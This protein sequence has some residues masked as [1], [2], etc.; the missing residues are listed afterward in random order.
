MK[1]YLVWGFLGAGKTTLINYLLSTGFF[2]QKKVVILE[3]ESGSE[4]VDGTML[5]S[6][7]YTVVDIKGGCVCCTLRLTLVE[8][9]Q[10]IEQEYHPDMVWMEAS[11]L[12]SLEDLKSIPGL[13]LDGVI[14]VLDV[15]QYRFLMKLNPVFYRRQFYF[16][17]IVFLTKTD[18]ID[19]ELVEDIVKDLWSFQPSLYIVR[20]YEELRH[21]DWQTFEKIWKEQ[22]MLFLP[23]IRNQRIP[24][25]ETH[26]FYLKT[27]VDWDFW[28]NDFV[29]LNNLFG[30]DIIRAKGILTDSQGVSRKYD[31]ADG[32]MESKEFPN[33]HTDGKNFLSIWWNSSVKHSPDS[34]LS[35]F[36]NAQELSCS[37]TE[38]ELKDESLCEFLNFDLSM[39]TPDLTDILYRLKRE[40]LAVCNPRL[41]V[42]FVTGNKIDKSHLKVGGISF[43]PSYIITKTL[44]N[45]DFYILMVSTV[46]K[47]L[48]SWIEAKKESGD[49]VEAFIADGIGSALAEEIVAYG[50]KKIEKLLQQWGLNASN[51]YSPGYCDWNVSEQKM[52]FSLL[53]SAFC[54]IQLTDSCLMLP[55]KSVS[56]LIGAGMKI[57]KKA[58]GCAICKNKNCY[59][60]KL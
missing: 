34:W 51:A 55:I 18:N 45:A 46:G 39:L 23:A 41:G 20:D 15:M 35:F 8:T 22:Q 21:I 17:S 19:V 33:V 1:V 2:Q 40:A 48:D 31:F 25:F 59:K 6:Y 7:Q 30:G 36:L 4:S 26:T 42:R 38:L 44:Q 54:D 53:P 43:Q 5:Q 3:N 24:Q 52:F 50:Q 37:V 27:P 47:E 32:C 10:K 14:S 12:A 28:E 13:A 9:L 56:S 60:R 29:R 49:V 16:S 58:Y 11:G 57:Q